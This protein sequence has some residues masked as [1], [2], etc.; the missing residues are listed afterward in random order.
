MKE[1]QNTRSNARDGQDD[2]SGTRNGEPYGTRHSTSHHVSANVMVPEGCEYGIVNAGCYGRDRTAPDPMTT[3][4]VES[5]DVLECV[6]GEENGEEDGPSCNVDGVVN[7]IDEVNT[8]RQVQE[9][10]YIIGWMHSKSA[11]RLG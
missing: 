2:V 5:I 8:R 1:N 11:W 3:D 6:D 10:N 4:V 9:R 7:M